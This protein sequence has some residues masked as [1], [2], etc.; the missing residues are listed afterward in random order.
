MISEKKELNENEKRV[1]G[2]L[3]SEGAH[4][5]ELQVDEKDRQ[6]HIAGE[7]KETKPAKETTKK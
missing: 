6:E 3:A 7:I 1:E 2:S 4:I 5:D